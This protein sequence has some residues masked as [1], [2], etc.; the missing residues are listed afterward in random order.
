MINRKKKWCLIFLVIITLIPFIRISRASET[1]IYN[2]ENDT[3]VNYEV[4][5][6]FKSHIIINNSE[7]ISHNESANY[8]REVGITNTNFTD[9]NMGVFNKSFGEINGTL[10]DKTSELFPQTIQTINE[11]NV[12]PFLGYFYPL[13]NITLINQTIYHINNTIYSIHITKNN[14]SR[15]PSD[16]RYFLNPSP[17][18][19]ILN[20]TAD[21]RYIFYNTTNDT[22]TMQPAWYYNPITFNRLIFNF[23]FE[24]NFTGFFNITYD[25]SVWDTVLV[26]S[27]ID[28][29][30]LIYVDLGTGIVLEKQETGNINYYESKSENVKPYYGSPYNIS[31]QV[32]NS[33]SI[34]N[35]N[36]IPFGLV[37][38]IYWVIFG[39]IA[40]AIFIVSYILL[41]GRKSK[42]PSKY[43]G[44]IL[45]K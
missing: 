35:S 39:V 30:Y 5:D 18:Q 43:E 15:L 6:Y 7:N 20:L 40:G 36:A 33:E 13:E 27:S 12:G 2:I 10:T 31:M 3:W 4:N 14:V 29:H 24:L 25:G 44:N 45:E 34:L 11:I 26:D 21:E 32:S 17:T 9:I 23:S 42:K 22:R 37:Y 8:Q 19:K 1:V 38:W 41:T 16:I 28:L